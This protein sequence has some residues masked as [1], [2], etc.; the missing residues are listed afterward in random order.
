MQRT[1]GQKVLWVPWP[2]S[3]QALRATGAP[4]V[5]FGGQVQFSAAA[6]P[7]AAWPAASST[8]A[9]DSADDSAITA[10]TGQHLLTAGPADGL[11]DGD[12]APL[13]G[14]GRNGTALAVPALPLGRLADHLGR[15]LLC[16]APSEAVKP[17]S[18]H[19]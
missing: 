6:A 17:L 4:V 1:H 7:A 2:L 5:A 8:S 12:R 18:E 10:L 14:W 11:A 9:D 15:A 16:H 3:P 13:T 19:K